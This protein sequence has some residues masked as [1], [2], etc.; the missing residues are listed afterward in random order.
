MENWLY[1]RKT[2]EW[3]GDFLK[4]FIYYYIIMYNLYIYKTYLTYYMLC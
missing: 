2:M 3:E 4:Y 1:S